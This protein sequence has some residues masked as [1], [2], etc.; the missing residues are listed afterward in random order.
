MTE[1]Q[2]PAAEQGHD[3]DTHDG[4]GECLHC[5]LGK[6]F[7]DWCERNGSDGICPSQ[8]G[9]S[10]GQFMTEVMLSMGEAEHRDEFRQANM[11]GQMMALHE[12]EAMNAEVKH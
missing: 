6:A 7:M 4:E 10:I 2:Q 3:H 1:Q 12:H 8:V 11:V 9:G 5:V